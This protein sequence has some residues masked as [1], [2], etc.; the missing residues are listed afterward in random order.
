[1]TRCDVPCDVGFTLQPEAEFL[2]RLA[3]V[4]AQVDYFEVAP[5]TTWF[6]RPGQPLEANGFARR[7]LELGELH[8][9]FFVAHGVGWSMG[10]C[11]PADELRRARWLERLKLDQAQFEYRWYTDHLGATTLAGETVALP[12]PM[13]MTDAVADTVA[14]NLERLQAIV[15]DV[16]VEN[17]AQTFML[18]DPLV[19]PAFLDRALAA[20]RHHLLLD[21]HNLVVT[22]AN[23]GFDAHAW[24]DA[25]DLSRVIE[26]H[27]AGGDVSDPAWLKSRRVFRLDSHA[28]AVPDAVWSLLEDVAPRCPNLRGITL[29][30]MEG[31]VSP[32]DVEGIDA[33][34]S[35][36]LELAR[37]LP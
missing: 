20:P 6:S 34:V 4:L 14:G 16:G 32:G 15:A 35:R 7:F 33:E 19:E 12:L 17:T 9:A 10:S 25:L 30:R 24:L 13:P 26:I 31:T 29:E 21:L 5:E 23:V 2:E 1:M 8:G 27:V 37:A 22:T 11:D 18:G 28:A 3:P 36:I